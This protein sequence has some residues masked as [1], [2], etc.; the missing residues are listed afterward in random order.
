M[1]NEEYFRSY[2]RIT[3]VLLYFTSDITLKFVTYLSKNTKLGRRFFQYEVEKQSGSRDG[4]VTRN[5]NRN[6]NFFFTI[7]NKND[8]LNNFII[9]PQDAE[10]LLNLLNQ[11]VLPW[12]YA[13]SDQYAFQYIKDILSVTEYS[14]VMYTQSD[15]KHLAFQ[16][17]VMTDRNELYVY[18]VKITVNG[19]YS[20]DCELEK[21]M[22]FIYFLK[23]D[24]YSAACSMVSYV[25]TEPYG[26]EVFRPTGLG[27]GQIED[28]WGEDDIKTQYSSTEI[29]SSQSNT[30]RKGSNSF[31]D[32][33]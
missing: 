26:I 3:D 27:G 22:G 30:N 6:M 25:K 20:F 2:D 8:F 18:G 33:L 29:K 13:D 16:P 12:F 5:I 23:C 9:R 17:T 19:V 10:M 32:N 7:D 11:K 28:R 24:M 1:S 4:M 15:I 14:P 21:F 31:L